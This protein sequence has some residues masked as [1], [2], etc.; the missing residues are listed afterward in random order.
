MAYQVKIKPLPGTNYSEVYKRTL[1]IYKKIKNRSKRRT[2]IRSSYFKKDKIFLD[3]FWQ[4]LHKKL[5]HRDKTRR[6]KYLPC[7]LELIRYSNDEPVSKENPNARS[8]ILH[9]FPG[10]TKTKEEFFVQ[11]KEDKRIGEKYFISVFPNEK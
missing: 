11:I 4:H 7:A 10:I 5:N 9:R 6:L 2:Y 8:E 1:D 3:I